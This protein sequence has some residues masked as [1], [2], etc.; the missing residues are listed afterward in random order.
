[1]LGPF[2]AARQ[3]DEAPGK[4]DEVRQALRDK[5]APLF[6]VRAWPELMRAWLNP[7]HRKSSTRSQ[8][9]ALNRSRTVLWVQHGRCVE[10]LSHF[11]RVR[12]HRALYLYRE[13]RTDFLQGWL[14][15][16][17]HDLPH[18]T[19]SRRAQRGHRAPRQARVLEPEMLEEVVRLQR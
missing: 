12:H 18:L 19:T 5:E 13:R 7:P 4:T 9:I 6:F 10:V 16:R 1:M 3:L 15:S 11:G 14:R 17:R 2:C 8:A